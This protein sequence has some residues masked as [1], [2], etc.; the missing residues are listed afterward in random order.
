ML[1]SY[2]TM[3]PRCPGGRREGRQGGKCRG[4]KKTRTGPRQRKRLSRSWPS[5]CRRRTDQGHPRGSDHHCSGGAQTHRSRRQ[6]TDG[7]RRCRLF[8]NSP[9]EARSVHDRSFGGYPQQAR[10]SRKCECTARLA[11]VTEHKPMSGPE[12]HE[13]L[14]DRETCRSR[15]PRRGYA[16][17]AG[18]SA[19]NPS[20]PASAT[21]R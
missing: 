6:G 19:G 15:R 20:P 5:Q 16:P 18:R 2:L 21:R 12:D 9:N 7:N 17:A 10:S 13:V 11:V 3:L 4:E 1:L 14:K 8:T